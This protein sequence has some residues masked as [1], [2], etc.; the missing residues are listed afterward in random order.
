MN[1]KITILFL[2]QVCEDI[3]DFSIRVGR[4][5]D[6]AADGDITPEQAAARL[7]DIMDTLAEF[8]AETKREALP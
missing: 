5:A 8:A 7:A 2:E 3:A 1:D 6:D 4:I